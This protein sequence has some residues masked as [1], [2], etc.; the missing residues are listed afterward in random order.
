M[1]LDFEWCPGVDL[2]YRHA[3]FQSAALPLSYPGTI[4]GYLN[5]TY[6]SNSNYAEL[7]VLMDFYLFH[8]RA[9]KNPHLSIPKFYLLEYHQKK[10]HYKI[11]YY[12]FSDLEHGKK[13]IMILPPIPKTFISRQISL[14][15]SKFS[16]LD[17]TFKFLPELTSIAKNALVCSKI[18]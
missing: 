7:I 2:N 15:A 6:L 17:S 16:S 18:R 12:F 5:L 1:K 9:Q 4:F 14:H 10:I 11:I 3:D 8:A 13:S